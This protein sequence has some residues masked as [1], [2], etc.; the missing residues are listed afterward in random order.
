MPLEFGADVTLDTIKNEA[1]GGEMRGS[2]SE[3]LR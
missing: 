1:F 2:V 3:R